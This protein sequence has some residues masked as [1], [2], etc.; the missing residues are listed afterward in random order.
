M[1]FELLETGMREISKK[2]LE[3]QKIEIFQDI[4]ALLKIKSVT[5]DR[6]EN[7]AALEWVRKK[8]LEMGLCAGYAVADEVILISAG[9][10]KWVL[11]SN[12]VWENIDLLKENIE[13]SGKETIG[14]L[15]H[16]DVVPAPGDWMYEPFGGDI[17]QGYIWGRGV[18]DDKGPLVLCLHGIKSL[19]LEAGASPLKRNAVMIIGSREEGSWTDIEAYNKLGIKIDFGFTPD[20]EFP[21]CNGEKGYVDVIFKSKR[22]SDDDGYLLEG[23][24][25]ANMVPDYALLRTFDVENNKYMIYES[26]GEAA[27]TAYHDKGINAIHLLSSEV[28]QLNLPKSVHNI[29]N[30]IY[31]YCGDPFGA[32]LGIDSGEVIIGEDYFHRNVSAPTILSTTNDDFRLQM[33][34]RTTWGYNGERILSLMKKA[35]LEYNLEVEIIESMDPMIVKRDSQFIMTLGDIYK[36]NTGEAHVFK[37]AYGASYAKAMPNIVSFGP[38][39]P[40]DLDTCHEVNERVSVEQLHKAAM[41]YFEAIFKLCLPD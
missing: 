37:L 35:A 19:I 11:E 22:N 15:A 31:K 16:V 9:L 20:G 10:G 39:F 17:E 24:S 2:Y 12:S 40:G 33:N 21:V 38:V 25:A 26:K 7:I 13:S 34:I 28:K 14:I 32:D 41:I 8:A 18:V 29:V 4:S 30:F 27:H 3:E 5:T 23:G 6:V 1:E 36:E